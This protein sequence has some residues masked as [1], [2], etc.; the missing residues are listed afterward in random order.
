MTGLGFGQILSQA[1][2]LTGLTMRYLLGTRRV[3]PM[4]LLG[5][6]PF[7]LA[8]SIAA[9][10]VT[11]YDVGV[12][13]ILMNLLLFQVVLIFVTLVNATSLVREEID[14]NTL[15]YLLTRPLSKPAI[16]AYKF[17]GYL[18]A[19]LILLIPPLV[20]AYGVT[21]S[22]TGDGFMARLDVLGAYVLAT[23][24]GAAAYGA[25]F[26]LFSVLFRKPLWFGLFIG[27]LYESSVGSLPGDVPKLSVVHY[28]RSILKDLI[29]GGPLSTYAT[30]LN[31]VWAAGILVVFTLAIL[32]LS[33]FQFQQ[34]EFR[35][36]A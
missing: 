25:L 12:F 26:F 29:D 31:A 7:I 11:T 16:A 15:P 35:A 8:G 24:L 1:V 9:A 28:P 13:Q 4:A 14:D 18:V 21:M 20:L 33:L 3:V 2:T 17:A 6:V 10:G 32:G 23:V 34:M 19:V 22:Y 30:D 5:F 27:F 36:K